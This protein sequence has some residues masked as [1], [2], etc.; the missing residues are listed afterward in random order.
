LKL[1]PDR[2]TAV[3][4]V[5][6]LN[7][8]DREQ[9]I[10]AVW[11]DLASALSPERADYWWALGQLAALEEDWSQSAWAYGQGAERAESSFLFW[12]KQGWAFEEL[13]QWQQ[14]E[15]A[16]RQALADRPDHPIAYRYLGW[17]FFQQNQLLEAQDWVDR[18]LE[19]DPDDAVSHS[20]LARILHR[21]G[22]AETAEE[23]LAHAVSLDDQ[24]HWTWLVML[25]DWRLELGKEDAALA[26]YRQA[27]EWQPG[28]KI[29]QERIDQVVA[30]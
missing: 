17:L 26:A 13:E 22:R 10:R 15:Q 25:G 4:L 27:L 7:R 24:Q 5:Q 2:N 6:I 19:V 16:Y 9:E 23:M 8:Q 1:D 18:A 12:I 29:I 20:Y 30:P 21:K 28:Q 3:Q 14:A 11:R